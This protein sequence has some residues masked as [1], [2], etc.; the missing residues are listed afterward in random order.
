MATLFSFG[1]FYVG[2][3]EEKF[4]DIQIHLGKLRIEYQGPSI[5][6]D[7]PVSPSTDGRQ[8]RSSVE[9]DKSPPSI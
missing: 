3:D 5:K 1:S 6:S 4:N 7:G 2:V 9:G 8:D